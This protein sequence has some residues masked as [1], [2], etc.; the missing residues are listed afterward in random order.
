M[1]FLAFLK[2]AARYDPSLWAPIIIFLKLWIAV[3]LMM[4][5]VWVGTMPFR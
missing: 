3:G 5:L 1:N 4:A 2:W